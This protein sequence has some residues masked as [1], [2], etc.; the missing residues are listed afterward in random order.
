MTELRTGDGRWGTGG[1]NP[2]RER[3]YVETMSRVLLMLVLAL[4]VPS[5]MS[6]QVPKQEAPKLKEEPVP[7]AYLPPA[8]MCRIWVDNVPAARQPAPTDCATAIRN[9]PPNARILFPAPK[10]SSRNADIRSP[11]GSTT[12][13]AKRKRPP[14]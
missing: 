14:G 5:G 8:G 11:G 6:A 3:G 13:T 10:A 9:R 1:Q 7:R 12:D 2:C 4:V